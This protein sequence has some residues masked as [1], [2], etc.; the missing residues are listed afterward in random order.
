MQFHNVG[1]DQF[2]SGIFSIPKNDG[3]HRFILNLKNLNKFVETSHFKLED[4]RTVCKLLSRNDFM[5]TIDLK[6]AYYLVPI[7][8]TDK[9]YL[10]Y[11]F[12]NKLYEYNCLAMGLNTAPFVFTKLLKPVLESE[13][14]GN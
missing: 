1:P 10:R 14:T 12:N 8:S 13:R 4:I 7:N 5:C 2:V 9:K 3:S 11:E 6:N